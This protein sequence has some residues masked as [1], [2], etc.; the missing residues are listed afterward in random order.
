MPYYQNSNS[1]SYIPVDA[2]AVST[3]DNGVISGGGTGDQEVVV[4]NTVF[5]WVYDPDSPT[6]GG[7]S[8]EGWFLDALNSPMAVA[9][10]TSIEQV[11]AHFANS[12]NLNDV[13]ATW[14]AF[15]NQHPG[16]GIVTEFMKTTSC[17]SV[18]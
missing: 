15:V 3:F 13:F 5:T 1:V 12:D 17:W 16:E 18:D 2:N 14:Q 11:D 8:G 10:I 4:E 9:G 6:R 7:F